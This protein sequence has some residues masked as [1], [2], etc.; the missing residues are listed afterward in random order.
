VN[1]LFIPI[2]VFTKKNNCKEL[3]IRAYDH[4]S[5]DTKQDAWFTAFSFEAIFKTIKHKPK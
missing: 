1:G 2:L 5:I 4:W 3:D